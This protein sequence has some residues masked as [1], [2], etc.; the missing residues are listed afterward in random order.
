MSMETR[1]PPGDLLGL[2]TGHWVARAVHTLARLDVA[3]LLG[4]GRATTRDLAARLSVHEPS[5]FRL[6]R[7]AASWG[8]FREV[9]PRTFELA[10][11]GSLLRSDHPASLRAMALF[12]GAEPHWRAWG[13][14]PRAVE[15]GGAAFAQVH[16]MGFFEYTARDAEF[17]RDFND[18]MTGM[19]AMASDAVARAC[20]FSGVRKLVD[21][22]GGHGHLL[23]SILAANPGLKGVV[24][25]LPEVVAGAR[26]RIA[27]AGLGGRCEA[28][29]GSFFEA[30]PP[31][32]A[33]IAKHIIHDWSDDHCHRILSRMVEGMEG[34]GRVFLVET[35]IPPGDEPH[36]GKLLDLEM[37]NSTDGGRERTEAEFRELFERAGLDLVAV[38]PTQSPVAVVEAVRR[39]S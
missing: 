7:A 5:L 14:F 19:S 36:F 21:V 30:L 29:A 39:D 33:Y 37:L 35:V 22:G 25:D 18:A 23:L 15:T 10:E 11:T 24:F 9:A 28:A 34:R 16:G 12:Q 4:E 27:G 2:I 8:L 38:H 6:M 17:A 32:D 1:D 26:H 31:A 13:A 20:D 3:T